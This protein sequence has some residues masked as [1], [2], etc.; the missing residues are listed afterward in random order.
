[1][2]TTVKH[3][4]DTKV[5][6]TISLDKSELDAAHHVALTKL[7]KNIKVPGFRKGKVPA[8]VAA[9]NVDPQALAEQT[10]E[11]ALSK[12]VAE[13]YLNEG[14]QALDRPAVEVKKFVPGQELEFTAETEVLPKVILGDY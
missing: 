13:A 5:E 9:K 2:K 1:M 14:L 11:D 8:S 4:S 10:L 12:A 7:A 3:L 6:L